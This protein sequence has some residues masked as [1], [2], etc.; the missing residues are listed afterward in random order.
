MTII[1][2]HV[3]G[4]GE[5]ARDAAPRR[6][7]TTGVVVGAEK[8]P[9]VSGLDAVSWPMVRGIGWALDSFDVSI[10]NNVLQPLSAAS[11]WRG[12]CRGVDGAIRRVGS[13]C[14][15]FWLAGRSGATPATVCPQRL[16]PGAVNVP[17]AQVPPLIQSTCSVPCSA[18][19]PSPSR[20]NAG[21][22][23]PIAAYAA[24]PG[25]HRPAGP[26]RSVAF[27]AGHTIAFTIAVFGATCCW[28]GT[29]STV[30]G[31]F[32]T[33]LLANNMG[34]MVRRRSS[35]SARPAPGLADAAGAILAAPR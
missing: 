2:G 33:H 34:L 10:T 8:R 12:H 11:G 21:A 24:G 6:R 35:S 18:V 16:V 27:G 25:R 19:W 14:R 5:H 22:A 29:Y 15:G 4:P 3:A 28:M 26:S 17:A 23:P 7:G 31:I 32:P 13:G 20:W 1:C 9:E 30:A